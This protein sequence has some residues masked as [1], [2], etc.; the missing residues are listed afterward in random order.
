[1]H[2]DQFDFNLPEHLIAQTPLKDRT[3][4][5]LMVLNKESKKIEHKHFTDI[6]QYLRKGDCLVLNDTRVLP[7]RLY[8]SKKDTGA[9]IE[10]LLL[11]QQNNDKWEVD[12]KST[13]LNSSHVS[14]SYAVFCLKKKKNKRT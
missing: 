6:K 1:M 3:S 12:R 2:I 5:R 13:R 11:H 10:V 8:G 4:S 7:A 14:I 9:K